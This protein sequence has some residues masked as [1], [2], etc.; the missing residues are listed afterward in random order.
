MEEN[1]LPEQISNMDDKFPILETD[2]WNEFHLYRGKA[3]ARF[4]GFWG[5]DDCLAW[6]LSQRLHSETLCDLA[7]WEA[8]GLRA[9][10]WA[11]TCQ[12]ATGAVRS[13]GWQ[14]SSASMPSWIAMTAN[15]EALF[16]K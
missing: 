14:N 15:K 3:N 5:Q 12:S 13:H 6:E 8:Q 2:D 4:Q 16:G 1:D 9:Y 11:H 7:Q 10:Q